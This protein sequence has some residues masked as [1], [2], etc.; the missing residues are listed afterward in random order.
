MRDLL[1]DDL[2]A[3]RGRHTSG[4]DRRG[5]GE[6]LAAMIEYAD[7]AL[8]DESPDPVA[9]RCPRSRRRESGASTC[10]HCSPST[11]NG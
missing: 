5:V 8:F 1:G 4:E 3:D 6:V 9:T 11:P 7:V 2:L 10:S